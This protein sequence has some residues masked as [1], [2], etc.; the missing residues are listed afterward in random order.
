VS[1]DSDCALVDNE[2]DLDKALKD[3]DKLIAFVYA[4]W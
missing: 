3:K 2:A 4:S 1:D